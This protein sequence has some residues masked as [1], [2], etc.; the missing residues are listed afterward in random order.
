[1]A[2]SN[3]TV[4]VK[5][6]QRSARTSIIT[7]CTLVAMLAIES[8]SRVLDSMGWIQL[9]NFNDPDLFYSL[10][11]HH[12]RVPEI[13]VEVVSRGDCASV[14]VIKVLFQGDSWM[15]GNGI[16]AGFAAELQP[17]LP[18]GVCYCLLNAGV[19]SFSP[20]PMLTQFKKLSTTR[21]D[22]IVTS[23][24]ETD[25][26]DEWVRYRH[27]R[28][29]DDSGSLVAVVPGRSDV[30]HLVYSYAIQALEQQPLYVLRLSERLWL[31]YV[32]LPRLYEDLKR[33]GQLP[34]EATMLTL[35]RSRDARAEFPERIEYFRRRLIEL[36]AAYR[37]HAPSATVVL[38]HHPHARALKNQ[39]A[40][41]RY[42][43]S[44]AS[45]VG[46]VAHS[47]EVFF[48]SAA[49]TLDAIHGSALFTTFQHADPFSH[50]T[51]EGYLRYG[52]AVA[53]FLANETS[54]VASGDP[55]PG[56]TPSFCA[57]HPA[58]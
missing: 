20:S 40:T 41:L 53:R 30:P 27:S 9:S 6:R 48:F 38:I 19:G 16:V 3:T 34:S 46:E 29:L 25:L 56:P 7:A 5:W 1:M 57:A 8:A 18:E 11:Q 2:R 47:E 35:Q 12:V 31:E 21:P 58:E 13:S 43:F 44:V 28:V 23:I 15:Q 10:A 37:T 14:P 39:D 42:H 55:A 36:I 26:M 4:G 22:F 49:E 52:R 24:D 51:P 32:L 33:R 17:R 50:L 45:V 54:L